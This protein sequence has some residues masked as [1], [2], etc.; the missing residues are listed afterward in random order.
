M[1]GLASAHG[2]H[3]TVAHRRSEPSWRRRFEPGGERAARR[4]RGRRRAGRQDG[5]RRRRG[6]G[7][8]G[9][10]AKTGD[11]A[12]ADD[13]A[14]GLRGRAGAAAPA[15]IRSPLRCR[16]GSGPGPA[17]EARHDRARPSGAVD[18]RGTCRP[19]SIA[20]SSFHHA[21]RGETGTSLAPMRRIDE[22]VLGTPPL[23]APADDLAP[24]QRRAPGEPEAR[25]AAHAADGRSSGRRSRGSLPDPPRRPSARSR[26]PAGRRR[27]TRPA[28][29]WLA[30]PAGGSARPGQVAPTSPDRPTRLPP[31][32]R[33]DGLGHEAGPGL[34]PLQHA[35]GRPSRVEAPTKAPTEAPTEAPHRFG[36]PEIMNTEH[37][38]A[39][40]PSGHATPGVA[41][42][43]ARSDQPPDAGR[44]AHPGG[45]P[46]GAASTTSSSSG[47]GGR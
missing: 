4:G 36:A 30:G 21:P 14:Q 44:R 38:R 11:L 1:S 3:P 29:A 7:S 42:R 40:G 23:R 19:P 16:E 8:R 32:G 27:G 37:G 10:H 28:P 47:S 5:A 34:A 12:V 26:T 15:P 9:L 6:H 25:P 43:V 20:R 18:R 33:G 24:A 41:G 46:R 13:P 35:G 17:R 2:V 22:R 31:P 45:G 39:T